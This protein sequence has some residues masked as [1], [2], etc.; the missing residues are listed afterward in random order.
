MD[1]RVIYGTICVTP[2]RA[3]SFQRKVWQYD[4][5]KQPVLFD[6]A[7]DCIPNKIVTIRSRDKP[8]INTEVRKLFKIAKRFHKRAKR[9]GDPIHIESFRNARREAKSAF[10]VAGSKYYKDIT[11]KLLDPDTTTIIL[12]GALTARS[13]PLT[14]GEAVIRY[15][16]PTV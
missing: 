7:Q 2:P 15:R 6:L 1:H 13:L 9:T 4:R 3:F 10:R 5:G 14:A 11:D 8:G 12:C 16:K